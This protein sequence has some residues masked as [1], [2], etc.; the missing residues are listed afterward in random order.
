MPVDHENGLTY[1]AL[2]SEDKN[3]RDKDYTGCKVGR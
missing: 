2:L 1:V 3:E